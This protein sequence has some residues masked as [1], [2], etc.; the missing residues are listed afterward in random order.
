MEGGMLTNGCRLPLGCI[1]AI[2]AMLIAAG[3]L[4]IRG[5]A[6]ATADT[7]AQVF[8]PIC[9]MVDGAAAANRLPAAFLARILWHESRLRSDATSRAGAEGVAQ[10]MPRTAAERGLADPR[11]PA[12]SIAE[13]ARLLADLTLR[14]GNRGL[15]AAAYNAGPGRVARWLRRQSELPAETRLYVAAVTGRP[16]DDWAYS[17]GAQQISGGDGEPCLAVLSDLA[18]SGQ[19]R[20]ADRRLR[21]L[22]R[23]LARAVGLITALPAS[24]PRPAPESPR[25]SE[26]LRAAEALCASVRSLGA[27]C[28]VYRR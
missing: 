4:G 27:P 23:A 5:A 11:D 3:L 2:A 18:R 24:D 6:A 12:P 16:A 7:P 20:T 21:V 15:A 22:D 26:S 28:G 1:A 10:F 13:A 17:A 14:L 8:E 19:G 9:R 25:A